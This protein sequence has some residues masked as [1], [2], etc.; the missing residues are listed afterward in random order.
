MKLASYFNSRPHWFWGV[1]GGIATILVGFLDFLTGPR[2]MLLVFYL[3]PVCFSAWYAGWRWGVGVACVGAFAWGGAQLIDPNSDAHGLVL[4]WNSFI[5]FGLFAV[6]AILTGKMAEKKRVETALLTEQRGL[7]AQIRARVAELAR[8]NEIL[9]AEVAEKT[10]AQTN[11]KILNETLEQR[12]AERSAAVEARAHDLAVSESALRRQTGILQSILNSMGDGV[13]VADAEVKDVLTNPA[14]ERLLKDIVGAQW[15]GWHNQQGQGWPKNLTPYPHMEYPL[16]RAIRGESFDNVEV[17]LRHTQTG[18]KCGWVSYSG[19]PLLDE[20]GKLQGGVVVLRD[21]SSSKLMEKQIAEVSD[22]EQCRL[23]QDLHDGLCQHL[24]S[25]GFA[26]ELLRESLEQ[27]SPADVKQAE[28]I[29][30]MINQGITQARQLARGLY[31]VRL[32]ADGLASALEELAEST[33]TLSGI[34]CEFFNSGEESIADRVAG[35]N[36]FRIAQEAVVNAIKHG[37]C[38]HVRIGLDSVE[39]EITLSVKDDGVGMPDNAQSDGGMGLHIMRY[40]AQMIGATIQ[41]RHV[42]NGTLV[43]CTYPYP[44]KI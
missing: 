39:E 17:L 12:V 8:A 15:T 30:E 33:K 38:K 23:G 9:K 7:E 25:I 21:I 32:E 34:E 43:V 19:R 16:L 20:N 11:L 41:W 27:K 18:E 35:A 10:L 5:G 24:V 26:T 2:L 13:I 36:L 31:P 22:R 40:R 6:A 1:G 29:A 4:L 42:K 28:T 37:R 44:K 3:A 14:A